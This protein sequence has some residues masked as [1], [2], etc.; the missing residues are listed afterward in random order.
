VSADESTADATLRLETKDR[1]VWLAAGD[2]ASSG[3]EVIGD[4]GV[5][6]ALLGTLDR[7]NPAFDI[8]TP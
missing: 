3:F 8:I 1:L 2:L 7:P 5:L 4:S 6:P